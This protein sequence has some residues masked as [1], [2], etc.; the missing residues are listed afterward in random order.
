MEIQ[1]LF[2]TAGEAADIDRTFD[3]NAHAL[4]RRSIGDW[5]DDEFAVVVEADEPTIEEVIDAGRQEEAV[6]AVEPLLIG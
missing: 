4:E 3:I 2:L 1:E 6:L 5:R